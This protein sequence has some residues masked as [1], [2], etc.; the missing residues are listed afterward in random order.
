MIPADI[1]CF[2][3]LFWSFHF[4]P[5]PLTQAVT[6]TGNGQTAVE[7]FRFQWCLHNLA[8][9][10]GDLAADMDDSFIQ[11]DVLPLQSQ[12]FASAQADS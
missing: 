11:I 4:S 10:A 7:I 5:S 2:S 12:K 6:H 3:E 9:D 1:F 8:V